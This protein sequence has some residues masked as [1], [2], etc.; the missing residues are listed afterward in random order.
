[1]SDALIQRARRLVRAA[2]SPPAASDTNTIDDL[3]D[4]RSVPETA[5]RQG[6]PPATVEGVRSFYGFLR[7]PAA[8]GLV[9]VRCAGTA[10]S[11]PEGAS[12]DDDR[13][14]ADGHGVGPTLHCLGRCYEAPATLEH[15]AFR[16]PR[17][18]LAR[19]S[20]VFRHLLGERP[21]LSALYAVPDADTILDTLDRVGLRG[22]GGAAFGTAAKWRAA[23]AARGAPKY[24]VANGDEGDPGSFVDRLLLEEDPHAILA[25]M[26]ACAAAI[27]AS[28]GIVYIRAEYPQ[29]AV[30]MRA[31]IAEAEAAS[32]VR[33][34]LRLSVHVGAGSYVCGEET[35]LLRAIE[36]LRAEPCPKPPYPAEHG[37]F[38]MPTVVQNVET[39]AIVPEVLRT[40]R[41]T[42]TKALSVSGAVE[43]PG[44]VEAEMGIS[45]Q[46]LIDEGAGGI[47]A[48]R[49]AKMALVGGP[50]GR[51]VPA[52][53]FGEVRLGYDTFP[54]LGHGGVVVLDDSVSARALARHLCSFA[55]AES[56]GACT[57]CRVGTAHLASRSSAADLSRLLDTLE[58]GS[59]CGFG[60]AVPRPLRDLLH[61]FPDEM[62][63]GPA[64]G[65][66]RA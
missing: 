16:V 13:D 36:G 38:G 26:Q 12:R 6:L 37:L 60:Q 55:A 32:L 52:A 44:A 14:S 8:T 49:T 66:V 58:C 3:R 11:F 34:G 65:K 64:N 30:V 22:R 61:H 47:P 57:P 15:G 19:P 54:G 31:A 27:G 63:P 41:R 56:C 21:A 42:S 50:L 48:G 46:A 40:R 25:G 59:M 5:A 53:L 4:G 7:A 43:Q 24:V 9:G 51:V 2:G 18:S 39:L 10:C 33:P 20:M 23:R 17:R 62:F 35:A 28:E 1:M 45:L 29:A